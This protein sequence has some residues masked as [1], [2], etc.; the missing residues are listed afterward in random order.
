[1]QIIVD[2]GNTDAVFGLYDQTTWHYIWRTPARPDEPADSYERRLRLWLLEATV[3][4]SAIKSTV[5]SSV[6]PNLT[7][8]LRSMLTELFGFEPVVVGPGVYPLLPIEILR[9]HE[10]G[11]DLVANALAA[12]TRYKRTCVVVDFGTAL[13]FTTVSGEGKILGVAIAPGLKTAIRSLFANTAQLPEVPIEVPSSALGTSTTH[14]IQA[15]VVLGYEGLVR[16]LVSRIQTE[17]NGDCIAVATGGLS[18]RIPSLRDVFTD[19]VPSLTLEG[20]RLIGEF[21]TTSTDSQKTN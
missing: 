8:T 3:P 14:A 21:V 9:P 13:T 11:A 12:F 15:G 19:I 5:L 17:L 18:G 6:V 16:T 7:P 10:I 4:L 20:V 1:M 2:I